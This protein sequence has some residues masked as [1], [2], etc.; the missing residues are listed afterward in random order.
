MSRSTSLSR[1][2][3]E[4]EDGGKKAAENG[5]ARA[6]KFTRGA[7]VDDVPKTSDGD[8]AEIEDASSASGADTDGDV[9]DGAADSNG[10]AH[11]Q[12][13]SSTT[14]RKRKRVYRHKQRARSF[15]S[16]AFELSG[17]SWC[18]LLCRRTYA[19]SDSGT[20]TSRRRHLED[21][22]SDVFR[23][24]QRADVAKEDV[25]ATFSEIVASSKT[26]CSK[27]QQTLFQ[28]KERVDK[29]VGPVA[30]VGILRVLSAVYSFILAN[31]SAHAGAHS[32][33]SFFKAVNFSGVSVRQY[34]VAV[35]LMYFYVISRITEDISEAGVFSI[36]TDLWKDVS[37]RYF[38][39]LVAYTIT[40]TWTPVSHLIALAPFS[41]L[42]HHAENIAAVIGERLTAF[43]A[44]M[45]PDP[46]V[47]GSFSDN[48]ATMVRAGYLKFGDEDSHRCANHNL[49]LVVR[50]AFGFLSE[51]ISAPLASNVVQ[52]AMCVVTFLRSSINI[53]RALDVYQ[54][55]DAGDD[56][57]SVL[58][59]DDT[60]WRG[61]YLA[62]ARMERLKSA[63]MHVCENRRVTRTIGTAIVD[64]SV[65]EA[66]FA[67]VH[68]IIPVLQAL[69]K[70]TLFFEGREMA[71]C[72]GTVHVIADLLSHLECNRNDGDMVTEL[73]LNLCAK[74][75]QRFS[76]CFSA[77]SVE[78]RAS[79]LSPLDFA[80]FP[81]H[82]RSGSGSWAFVSQS[83]IERA[84]SVLADEVFMFMDDPSEDADRPAVKGHME[85]AR[86]RIEK[87]S[88]KPLTAIASVS[89]FW[90]ANSKLAE[91]ARLARA[92]LS[93]PCGT[94]EVERVFSDAGLTVS[95]IR[96]RLGATNVEKL[97]V[98]KRFFNQHPG[99][100]DA[101][102]KF[103]SEQIAKDEEEVLLEKQ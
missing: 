24:L 34:W 27:V 74:L 50:G 91:P 47:F 32:F 63:V 102:A 81:R 96:N 8:R 76:H 100:F 72:A 36:G 58:R 40:T 44:G 3:K 73:K 48:E 99:C 68:R 67:D 103:I 97:V 83:E 43:T 86:A 101:M 23:A 14:S 54:Q 65:N 64:V 1:L 33:G 90:Q 92:Y 39:G 62:L 82:V 2:M 6:S 13:S 89:D 41:M 88:R 94:A 87:E 5:G 79:L 60:R 61:I 93:M 42:S 78:L 95:K 52:N 59:A 10:N 98:C 77:S 26:P 71:L 57:L 28:V 18:C 37:D 38:L 49:A 85:T 46:I 9:S 4:A 75:Q 12:S 16:V 55:L 69:D 29:R 19:F 25:A 15:A 80:K 7:G 84:W 66:L 56:V 30:L 51:A 22:H 70:A 11:V 45:S 31:V 53:T 21:D 20:T 35:D 17:E